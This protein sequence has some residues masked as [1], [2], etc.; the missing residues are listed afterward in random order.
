MMV[1]QK[2]GLTQ[3]AQTTRNHQARQILLPLESAIM[4]RSRL[5]Q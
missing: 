2:R 1:E 3:N 5:N 4:N